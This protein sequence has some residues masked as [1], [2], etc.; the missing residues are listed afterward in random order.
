MEYKGRYTTF[1]PAQIVTYPVSERTNKVRLDDLV[2]PDQINDMNF[3][4][5][6]DVEDH[7]DHLAREIVSAREDQRPVCYLPEPI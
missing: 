7:I 4:L 5:P 6:R 1:N 3:S 2:E